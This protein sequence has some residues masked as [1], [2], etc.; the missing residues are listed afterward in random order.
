MHNF[1]NFYLF[2]V[3]KQDGSGI[4]D[5]V[6]HASSLA[7]WV[8][9]LTDS[10][11]KCVQVNEWM[12]EFTQKWKVGHEIDAITFRSKAESWD[13]IRK[14]FKDKLW[15][16]PL[17]L[18]QLFIEKFIDFNPVEDWRILKMTKICLH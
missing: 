18:L 13:F 8:I 14:N 2:W 5:N 15:S 9:W 7:L 3:I 4:Y 6:R 16:E 10:F 12:T 17:L 11:A 1:I